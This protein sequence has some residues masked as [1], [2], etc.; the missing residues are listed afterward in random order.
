MSTADVFPEAEPPDVKIQIGLLSEG[1][2]IPL[3]NI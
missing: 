1:D 3:I 2:L